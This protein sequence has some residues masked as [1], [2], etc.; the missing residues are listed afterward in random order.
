M[1]IPFVPA[2]SSNFRAGRAASIQWIVVHYTANDGDTDAGNAHYLT[3]ANLIE[4]EK[5]AL[6]GG[7]RRKTY[8]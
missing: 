1:G 2:H 7:E 6:Q 5:T 3:M 8:D 4:N